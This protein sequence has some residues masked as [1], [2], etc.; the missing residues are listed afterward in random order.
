MILLHFCCKR[1]AT[2]LPS[3][4]LYT[5]IESQSALVLDTYTTM[6]DTMPDTIHN[7]VARKLVQ[8]VQTGVPIATG[9][10]AFQRTATVHCACVY[11]E[12]DAFMTLS[13]YNKHNP[14]HTLQS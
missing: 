14:S 7:K 4:Y 10:C 5:P 13:A 1:P 6:P 8:G 3:G 2:G 11:S 12:V 9:H